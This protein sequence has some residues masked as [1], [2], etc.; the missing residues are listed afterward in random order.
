MIF[1]TLGTQA[2]DF[3]RCLRMIDNMIITCNIQNTFVAQ[4][5]YTKY[6]SEYISCF[7]FV[8]ENMYQEYMSTCD[9]VITHAGT[10]A[11][12]SAIKKGKK[13][14][15]VARLSQYGE[16]INDHQ[17]EI[18]NKLASEGYILD[19]TH[20]IIDAWNKIEDFQPR[21]YDFKC[22]IVQSI[23]QTLADWGIYTKDK[24]K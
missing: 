12:F 23:E 7:D 20:S 24:G 4:V 16:M 1:I 3:S 8:P 2:C 19:G 10:G 5:G 17:I 9:V 22:S 6:R 11:L 18:V 14:I 13:V 15:A 21:K